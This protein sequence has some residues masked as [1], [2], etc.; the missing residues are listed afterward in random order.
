MDME[1]SHISYKDMLQGHNDINLDHECHK[2]LSWRRVIRFCQA[3]TVG[4]SILQTSEH[5]QMCDRKKHVF[6]LGESVPYY[7]DQ[8]GLVINLVADTPFAIRISAYPNCISLALSLG[9]HCF[10]YSLD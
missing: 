5:A 4:D 10:L 2:L 1:I 3:C 9:R 8:L 7:F 6:L